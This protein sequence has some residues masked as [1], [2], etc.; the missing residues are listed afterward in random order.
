MQNFFSSKNQSDFDNSVLQKIGGKANGLLRL[1]KLHLNVPNWIVIPAD[2]IEKAIQNKGKIVLQDLLK[3][4]IIYFENDFDKGNNKSQ[5]FAVRSSAIEEDGKIL[6]FAGQFETKL[7]IENKIE[8]LEKAVQ[9]V[10]NSI[11]S[12]RIKIYQE[13]HNATENFDATKK[14]KIAIII[15]EMIDADVSGVAFGINPMNGSRKETLINSVFGVG[16]GLVSGNLEA[17]SFVT[18]KKDNSIKSTIIK[19]TN[20][21]LE[22]QEKPTLNENQILE[23]NKT[24]KTLHK[25]YGKFQDIEF[26]IKNNTFYFLQARP[27]TGLQNT[28]TTQ[29]NGG[30]YTLWDNSN[31]VESY[32]N[33]TTPL[34]FS[35]ISSSYKTAYSLFANYMGVDKKTIQNN[36]KIFENTLGLINGRVYYNL[37]TWYYMLALL[38]GYSINA[39]FMEKMM[40]VNER[41]DIP[42]SQNYKISKP[43]AWWK[44]TKTAATMFVRFRS[45]PKKR[46][47][48]FEDVEKI[49]SEYKQINFYK[50]DAHEL[51]NLYLNFEKK[52][53][54]EWK[55][56]LL[57]DF[58]AMIWY[59][60]LQKRSQK[61]LTEAQKQ[62]N[63]YQNIHNDLLCGSSDIISVEPIHR[64]IEIATFIQNNE[65]LKKLF[66]TNS[67][68]F[69]WEVLSNSENLKENNNKIQV[70]QKID[71]FITDFGDRCVGELK[72]ETISYTQNPAKFIKILKSYTET[73]IN[74][75]NLST[76]HEEQIRKQAEAIFEEN[77]KNKFI[78]KLTFKNTLKKAR[79]LV[80]A[81]EN[82]RYER[83]RAFGI[84]REIFTHIGKRFFEESIIE[85]ERDV[86]YMTKEE[87]F[88]FIEGR[89]VTQNI[90]SLIQLRKAEFENY[91]NLAV[92]SER[93]ASYGLPYHAT[94]FFSRKKIESVKSMEGETLKGIGCSHGIVR[95]KVQVVNN[96]EELESLNGNILVTTSTDPGWVV[97][98]PSASAILVERGSVLSHS[99]IVSREMGIPCIVGLSG[100]LQF[101]KTGDE[102][103]M[104]GSTGEVNKVRSQI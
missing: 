24:L 78:Q 68:Q 1:Q 53:L 76:N 61:F 8:E 88:A 64:T 95:G 77:L 96:P 21:A 101:L 80:S 85:S 98:F 30:E 15:Q 58:F 25:E 41:F 60:M 12:E 42:K 6:S 104:D 70:K 36:E 20:V 73:N 93:F 100:L 94:D 65:E 2:E 97:L 5:F 51:M 81:R 7:F 37:K 50:K 63:K 62:S 86:F 87:I 3:E 34:T 45:L 57:N 103:E 75:S 32:P 47:H 55:A 48:F 59:G 67:P 18:N 4:I 84:V 27:I 17:D 14:S 49:I 38:P 16:E 56:P 89:S 52:L 92:P 11:N 69:I 33:T 19:K 74:Q 54:N 35:F 91:Q 23:I 99:A 44:I 102:V 22:K 43:L 79:E 13:N 39:R 31:I 71:E 66:I 46:K 28:F 82:L 29:K 10:Y 83:T 90:A 40:G 72:L 9:E 26:C